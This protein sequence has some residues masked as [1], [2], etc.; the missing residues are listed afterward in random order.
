MREFEVITIEDTGAGFVVE[1]EF[2]DD[3]SRRRFPY[4]KG[5]GWELPYGEGDEP[6]FMTHITRRLEEEDAACTQCTPATLGEIQSAIAGRK[7]T[8]PINPKTRVAE[9]P[10]IRD[11]PK[12]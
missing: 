3:R 6:K 8:K 2:S 7:F 1:I 11:A 4:P 9:E 12:K 5:N 10:S